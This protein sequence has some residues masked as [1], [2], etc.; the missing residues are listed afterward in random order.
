MSQP[1]RFPNLHPL[2]W[3]AGPIGIQGPSS[4]DS[5][6]NGTT[7]T[8]QRIWVTCAIRLSLWWWIHHQNLSNH[9]LLSL[10][11]PV[12]NTT[13]AS[14]WGWGESCCSLAVQGWWKVQSKI[15]QTNILEIN[16][17]F[18]ALQAFSILFQTSNRQRRQS[19]NG[20]QDGTHSS[21]MLRG[22]YLLIPKLL[23]EM[24]NFSGALIA[25]LPL[26]PQRPPLL[27]LHIGT[28][29]SPPRSIRSASSGPSPSPLTSQPSSDH[30]VLKN[31]DFQT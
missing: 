30:L 21:T 23:Q 25:I 6:L 2:P 5:Y 1:L 7:Y 13:D 11:S 18:L 4:L 20:R 3:Y 19:H 26:R 9:L 12:I 22:I 16:A 10:L 31:P 17:A 28:S 15:L 24:D 27:N 14:Q 8:H 29:D